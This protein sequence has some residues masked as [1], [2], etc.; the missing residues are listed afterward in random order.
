MFTRL[1]KRNKDELS[2]T[3]L[4]QLQET[5][6]VLKRMCDQ[7][8]FVD[9][10]VPAR[11]ESWRSMLLG[12]FAD[13]RE[14]HMDEL[15]PVGEAGELRNGDRLVLTLR[16]HDTTIRINTEVLRLVR[17]GD[18]VSYFLKLPVHSEQNQ[19]RDCWRMPLKAH[20]DV[21]FSVTL[22]QRELRAAQP[23]DLSQEGIRVAFPGDFPE[24]EAGRSVLRDC[25]LELGDLGTV[26]CQLVVRNVE[27]GN[28]SETVIGAS[29]S[30]LTGF[31]R[32]QISSFLAASQRSMLRRIA[33]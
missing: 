14:L 15:F 11:E 16:D 4:A 26:R 23:M 12:V 3:E 6:R 29:F 8:V 10:R 1:L 25:R 9:V 5:A 31:E 20:A 24:M 19:R 18:F 32:R 2:A 30:N 17:D 33:A 22:G 13:A 27:E 21:G 7:H 28:G